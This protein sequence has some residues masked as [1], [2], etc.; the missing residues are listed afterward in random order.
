MSG[1]DRHI[2]EFLWNDGNQIYANPSTIAANIDYKP[3]TVRKRMR[4]LRSVGFVEYYDE[5][6]GIYRLAELGEKY[7]Q[8]IL[9]SEEIAEIEDEYDR[10]SDS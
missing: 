6:G 10:L 4:K 5:Q 8:D 2:L 9:T 1:S 3:N 7:L